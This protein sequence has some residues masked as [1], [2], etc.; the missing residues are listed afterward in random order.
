M[1]IY[2]LMLIMFI[3]VLLMAAFAVT[4]WP[5]NPKLFTV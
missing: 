4:V 5:P 3:C 2:V 1:L